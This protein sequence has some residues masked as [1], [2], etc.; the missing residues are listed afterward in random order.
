M[1]ERE[2][3]REREEMKLASCFVSSALSLLSTIPS[4]SEDAID[5]IHR[6]DIHIHLR[7]ETSSLLSLMVSASLRLFRPHR[8][9][10]FIRDLAD[11]MQEREERSRAMEQRDDDGDERGDDE[12]GVT[13]TTSQRE[14]WS[15]L[16]GG[17]S[18]KV[19]KKCLPR[20]RRRFYLHPLDVNSLAVL[21]DLFGHI[22]IIRYLFF[23]SFSFSLFRN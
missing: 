10:L 19:A 14:D 5:A 21:Y 1:F 9:P 12:G 7:Y 4:R 17:L 2:N 6:S 15:L 11:L 8:T 20:N 18:L 13:L 16:S 22:Q 3:G 23:F